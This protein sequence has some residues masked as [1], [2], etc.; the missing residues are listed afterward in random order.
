MNWLKENLGESDLDVDE[1]FFGCQEE[2]TKE[3]RYPSDGDTISTLFNEIFYG[4]I[5]YKK[6]FNKEPIYYF[7]EPLI[8][9]DILIIK[10]STMHLLSQ[11]F[12]G[13]FIISFSEKT[14]VGPNTKNSICTSNSHKILA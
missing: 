14:F 8:N 12:N 1:N 3:L 4:P 2:I 6:R 10:E 7:D 9:K 13:N 5:L 11:K